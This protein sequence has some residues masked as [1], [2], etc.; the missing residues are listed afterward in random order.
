MKELNEIAKQL[1]K[2]CPGEA[3]HARNRGKDYAELIA[4]RYMDQTARLLTICADL[5]QQLA[6]KEREV[7]EECAQVVQEAADRVLEKRYLSNAAQS[8]ALINAILQHFK[9]KRDERR[10]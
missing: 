5:E 7:V 3:F 10:E 4:N 9:E 2:D 6:D 8:I 1:K